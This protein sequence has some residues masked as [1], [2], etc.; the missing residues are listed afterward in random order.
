MMTP[1]TTN[2]TTAPVAPTDDVLL[3]LAGL[4]GALLSAD[5]RRAL[6][7]FGPAEVEQ[8]ISEA[9]T[10]VPVPEPVALFWV[11]TPPSS[12]ERLAD[13]YKVAAYDCGGGTTDLGLV[14][15][16][17]WKARNPDRLEPVAVHVLP[18]E[19]GRRL[20]PRARTLGKLNHPNL[21][22][23]LDVGAD[24]GV[25]FVV[26]DW[27][28]NETLQG[29]LKGPMP[30]REAAALVEGLARAIDYLHNQGV[31]HRDVKPANVFLAAPGG[32]RLGGFNRLAFRQD[33]SDD[34]AAEDNGDGASLFQTLD[35]SRKRSAGELAAIDVHQLGALFYRLL[36][37]HAPVADTS[38]LSELVC[39]SVACAT[40]ESHTSSVSL[41]PRRWSSRLPAV[42][43]RHFR[44]DVPPSLEAICL[45]YLG[46]GEPSGAA[47]LWNELRG[48][49]QGELSGERESV[50]E[51]HVASPAL[52]TQTVTRAQGTWP[53][54]GGAAPA[55]PGYEIRERLG[56]GCSS[57]VYRAWDRRLQRPVALKVF[58]T[59]HLDTELFTRFRSEARAVAALR[60]SNIIPIHDIGEHEGQPYLSLGYVDGGSLAQRTGGQPYPV[61][62][63]AEL[64]VKLAEAVQYAHERGIVHR[65]LKPSN[66]MVDRDG[67]PLIIDFGLAKRLESQAGDVS[68]MVGTVLGTPC[69]MAPEQAAGRTQEIGPATDVYALGAILYELLTGRPPFRG[70]S[71]LETLEQV[72]SRQPT[73]P[74]K[75]RREVPCDLETIC[76]KC[77]EKDP[78]RRYASARALADDLACYLAGQPIAA[79]P[80]PAWERAVK[81]ATRQPVRLVVEAVLA[82]TILLGLVPTVWTVGHG[83][84][85]GQLQ[86]ELELARAE[87]DQARVKALRLEQELEEA[88]RER[89]RWRL[90][91]DRLQQARPAPAPEAVPRSSPSRSRLPVEASEPQEEDPITAVPPLLRREEL[92]ADLENLHRLVREVKG[93][94][95]ARVPDA[96]RTTISDLLSRLSD[97]V[98]ALAA[99]TPAAADEVREARDYLTTITRGLTVIKPSA[100][101]PDR[102]DRSQVPGRLQTGPVGLFFRPPVSTPTKK[103]DS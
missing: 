24:R 77:L 64:L 81:W 20:K 101:P 8:L 52:M 11:D 97:M 92:R 99:R 6:D 80:V 102:V 48:F 28:G 16:Q 43:P 87:A 32:P 98:G 18:E 63:S 94:D 19:R 1:D 47:G 85:V 40:G 103:G 35:G 9:Y 72:R 75:L 68:T 38:R 89:D 88:R 4:D 56:S 83:Q 57:H 45:K 65:D 73:P 34:L 61:R 74:Q 21:L 14:P 49:L 76:L 51:E 39:A 23:V 46:G 78:R 54:G 33:Q 7:A 67:E 91:H 5:D 41:R 69:Y 90:E 30:P 50:C 2:E 25:G 13:W 31:Y 27:V 58:R 55:I 60:H 82:A 66:V 44:P 93:V 26:T 79:R 84:I 37:G 100:P 10:P 17:V 22:R 71:S 42:P 62:P 29:R 96:K 95:A 15:G 59:A 70:S 12:E 36:T 86:Q 53:D 3:L